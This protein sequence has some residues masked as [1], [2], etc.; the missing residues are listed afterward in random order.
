[1]MRLV[2]GF[3]VLAQFAF[4]VQFVYPDFKQCYNK[5]QKSF[6]Y[7]GPIRAIAVG[8]HSAVAYLK[9][10]PNIPFVKYD[11][12]L[13]LYLFHTKQTLHPVRLKSTHSLKVGEWIGGM[14]EDS[15][16]VGNF[17]KSGDVLDSMYLQNTSLKPNSIVSCLC[18]DVYGLGVGKGEFIGSEYIKRF[19]NSKDIFYGD[20]GARFE[21]KDGKFYV[22]DTDPF[23]KNNQLKVGDEILSINSKKF[24]SLKELNQAIL[25]AKPKSKIQLT[26]KRDK[27]MMS[28]L[29]IVTARSGGGNIEDSFL[30]KKGFIFDEKMKIVSIQKDSFAHKNGLKVGDKLLEIDQIPVSSSAHL[31]KLLS[32][33]KEKE[34]HLLFDRNDF[35]FFVN[36][37]L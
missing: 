29:S 32:D 12:F 14:D 22:V 26:I 5:N 1:M 27:K 28:F 30:E 2:L 24:H 36:L 31:R 35:Q 18:C 11:P 3:V 17:A 25:F 13:N 6:V 19:V 37:T 34:V 16:F 8:P 23:Y 15:L 33:L 9:T 7:I 10:K 4:S 21:K 20:I